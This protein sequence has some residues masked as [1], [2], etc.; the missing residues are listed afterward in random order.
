MKGDLRYVRVYYSN[1]KHIDT[2]MNKKLTD[3][4]I[5]DYFRVGKTFNIGTVGDVIA[6]VKKVVIHRE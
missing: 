6:K 3:K 2:S 5:R 4:Q 1:G